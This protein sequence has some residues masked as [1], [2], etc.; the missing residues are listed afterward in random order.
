M[1]LTRIA[2]LLLLALVPSPARAQQQQQVRT[3]NVGQTVSGELTTS[4]PMTRS[5]KAPYHVWTMQG[6]RGQRIIIDLRSGAFDSY[7]VLRDEEGFILGSDDDSGDDNDS[8]LHTVLPRDGRY[9]IIATAYTENGVGSYTLSVG[10]WEAP[11]APPAGVATTIVLGE[12]KDGLL[13]PGDEIAGDGPYQDR[14]MLN[15]RAGQRL[16]IDMSSTDFDS[17]LVLLAPDGTQLATDDDG[18]GNNSASIGLRVQVAGAY[19]VVA[20]SVNDNLRVGA[21]RLSVVE[22]T[23]NYA[24]P[25]IAAPI[26]A[27]E[28]KE[29][30]LEAGDPTGRRG[31]EDR[32]T[33]TARAGQLAR[34]DV[35]S[36]VFDSYATLYIN[37]MAVDSNDDGGDGNNARLSTVLSQAGQ[38]TLVVSSFSQSSSGGRYTVAV[39]VSDAPP[40]AGRI[41]R[42]SAGQR[43]SGRLEPGD[44][45]REGGGF[46]DLWEFDGRAGQDIMIEMHSSDLDPYLELRDEAGALVAENDDGGDGTGALIITRLPR[47]GRYRIVARSFAERETGGLYELGFSLGGE[48][49]RPGRFL[50]LREGETVLGRLEAGD[51]VVGDSTYADVFNYRA[52]REGDVII[53]LRSGDFDAYL[54]VKDAGGTTLATDDD[55]GDGTNSQLTLHVQQGQTI[56]VFANSYGEDRAS[57]MYRLSLRYTP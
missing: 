7:L 35:V 53:D 45:P 9:R 17:Y 46:Q 22:E 36:P 37:G 10:G 2:P 44:Q 12:A 48:I 3:I 4:D 56:R 42:I 39:N 55:G 1:R 6:R 34:I 28:T 21:Y 30:R 49:A 40:G 38:Y 18:G 50:D 33:F 8:R 52:T 26:A 47:A 29:G 32:W 57:G 13:E 19:T 54:L 24:D 5:R 15:T 11:Q 41:E 16:R 14:W 43:V 25:G 23:G 20:T 51:S 31:L 27:G